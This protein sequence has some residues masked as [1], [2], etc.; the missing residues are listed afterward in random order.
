MPGTPQTPTTEAPRAGDIDLGA[1]AVLVVKHASA[2][3]IG[4]SA[5]RR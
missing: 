3:R 1:L 4:G 5:A 2:S